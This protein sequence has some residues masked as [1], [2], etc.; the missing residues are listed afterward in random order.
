MNE[1]EVSLD[2]LKQIIREKGINPAPGAKPGSFTAYG[3][4]LGNHG[5]A[6]TEVF[7][8][9]YKRLKPIFGEA[10]LDGF[11]TS[12]AHAELGR[13]EPKL[14]PY[15]DGETAWLEAQKSELTVYLKSTLKRRK[16]VGL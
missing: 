14:A 12:A 15:S 10:L 9:I 11:S 7:Y 5:L 13:F 16:Q 3:I 6:A 2:Q 1:Q 4:V 8:E